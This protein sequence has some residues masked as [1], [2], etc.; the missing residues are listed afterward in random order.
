MAIASSSLAYRRSALMTA[1][2]V[3]VK[4]PSE[5][6]LRAR[7]DF[8]DFC[9]YMGKAPANHML[10]WHTELCTGKDT[11]CLLGIGGPNTAILA[12]RG[13]AKS[14]V[15]GLF[16]AWM[17]GRHAAAKQMLRIL[18]IAYMV[19][20]SRAKSATIKGILT[21]NKYREIFPM[22][23][24]SKIK[25]SDEYWSIDYDFAGIDTAGEEAFTIACGG[26]KGAITSKRSQL[27]LIDDPIKSAAPSTIR[28][29][30]VRW[31][32][33]G[34][35]LLHRRCFKEQGLYA[36]VPVFT[37]TTFMQPYLSPRTTGNR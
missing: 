27:V 18:Y 21:S 23:R 22:V 34:L 3:T 15:L 28:I 17:I 13:S 29:F 2:K 32:R 24:L 6:V 11:E 5:A 20:I 7:D 35:M 26:L 10:E 37:L 30:A 4:P 9:V 1:T 31:N 14:T 16:A 12:P 33:H 25:R 19:D 8:K 36:W